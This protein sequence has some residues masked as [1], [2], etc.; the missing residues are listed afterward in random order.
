MARLLCGLIYL[1]VDHR[2]DSAPR[3]PSAK[4]EEALV[5]AAWLVH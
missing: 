5:A 4:W 1:P 2:S 3:G